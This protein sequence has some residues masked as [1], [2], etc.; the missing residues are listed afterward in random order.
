MMKK[1]A[2]IRLFKGVTLALLAF[3]GIAT[4]RSL[5]PGLCTTLAA[6]DNTE[7]VSQASDTCCTV[8]HEESDSDI[9]GTPSKKYATCALCSLTE[10]LANPVLYTHEPPAHIIADSID[11]LADASPA[12]PHVWTPAAL[13]APPVYA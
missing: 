2:H 10:S 11:T 8:A 5:L 7:T 3:Y 9:I 12:L 1:T 6:L 4:G 13:R